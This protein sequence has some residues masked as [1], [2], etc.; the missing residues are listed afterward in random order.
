MPLNIEV[1]QFPGGIGD[2]ADDS[3][4][5]GVGSPL[6]ANGSVAIED[7]SGGE[8]YLDHYSNV[9]IG[10]AA[11][12]SVFISPNGVVRFTTPGVATQ[13]SALEADAATTHVDGVAIDA[14]VPAWIT[15]RISIADAVV[16]GFLLG[17]VPGA[18][19]FAPAAGVY[20]QSIAASG[21]VNL[22]VEGAAQE[23]QLI[24]TLAPG[25][26][27]FIDIA[28]FWDGIKASGQFPGG[29]GSFIPN[30]ANLPAVGL[31][32]TLTMIEG[33]G[34]ATTFDVDLLAFG[35]SR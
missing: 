19:A 9:A 15:A 34:G 28:L 12:A 33:A 27:G 35:G 18:S 24:G 16:N 2:A 26:T 23:V 31:N 17:F 3:I 10:G 6:N 14:G 5:N 29:G 30:P 4:L 32:A 1:T 21:D 7:F 22:I 8:N 25:A 13:G 11:V 20:L